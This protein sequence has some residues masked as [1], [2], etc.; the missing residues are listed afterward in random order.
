LIHSIY[1]YFYTFFLNS[2]LDVAIEINAKL[3]TIVAIKTIPKIINIDGGGAGVL[4]K[5]ILIKYLDISYEVNKQPIPTHNFNITSPKLLIS[6]FSLDL[7]FIYII[8][9]FRTTN[10]YI[11]IK[12][13]MVGNISILN[14][15]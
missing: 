8:S 1:K 12:A 6:Y 9:F 10:V 4:E 5:Y 2:K 7:F 13:M 15:D 14:P 3:S 11:K